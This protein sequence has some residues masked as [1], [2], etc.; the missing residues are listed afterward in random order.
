MYSSYLLS[1]GHFLL[2]DVERNEVH[3]RY[4]PVVPFHV[5]LFKGEYFKEKTAIFSEKLLIGT[6]GFKIPLLPRFTS[7]YTLSPAKVEL[8]YFPVVNA[9]NEGKRIWITERKTKE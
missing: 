4:A 7:K 1:G 9:N 3:Y 5:F 8:M 6:Y 2:A